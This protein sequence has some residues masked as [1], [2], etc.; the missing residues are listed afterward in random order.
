M[1][2]LVLALHTPR[3]QEVFDSAHSRLRK[4][5]FQIPKLGKIEQVPPEDESSLGDQQMLNVPG[6]EVNNTTTK[7][8]R[9]KKRKRKKKQKMR[10]SVSR[11]IAQPFSTFS[12]HNT[13]THTNSDIMELLPDDIH[14]PNLEAQ[15]TRLPYR[16]R[17]TLAAVLARARSLRTMLDKTRTVKFTPSV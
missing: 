2:S 10:T 7:Q 14:A 1:F 9:Y 3:G 17:R 5:Y 16:A 15:M 12:L 8:H 13:S 6:I 4:K 11:R